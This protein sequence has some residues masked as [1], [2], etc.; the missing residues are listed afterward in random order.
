MNTNVSS[1]WEENLIITIINVS[2]KKM[3]IKN[4]SVKK[5]PNF[6]TAINILNPLFFCVCSVYTMSYI[7]LG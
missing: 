4:Q 3:P 2:I 7:F 6:T 1:S 5:K